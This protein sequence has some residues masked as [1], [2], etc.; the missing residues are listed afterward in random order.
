MSLR[1][2][3]ARTVILITSMMLVYGTLL[4][5]WLLG[6]T[7]LPRT[8]AGGVVIAGCALIENQRAGSAAPVAPLPSAGT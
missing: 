2:L 5:W 1:H 7:P 6:E 8:L 4:A 3:A